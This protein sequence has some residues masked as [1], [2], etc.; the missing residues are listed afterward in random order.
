MITF[1]NEFTYLGVLYSFWGTEENNGSEIHE[2]L[3]NKSVK[4]GTV[5]IIR[6]TPGEVV[7]GKELLC[8]ERKVQTYVSSSGKM[9]PA[10]TMKNVIFSCRFE[11]CKV[12][13]DDAKKK[14]G[15]RKC[16]ALG[17][18]N[19]QNAYLL[20]QIKLSD[21]KVKKLKMEYRAN[22]RQKAETTQFATLL[23]VRKYLKL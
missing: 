23:F 8:H 5:K 10:K 13:S 9:V 12:L 7:H 15:F 17:D 14:N 4:L 18:I 21:K 1:R 16:W 3:S 6:T 20:P 22:Q 2:M 19:E 11:R